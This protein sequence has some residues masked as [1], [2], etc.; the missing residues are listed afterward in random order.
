MISFN[1]TYSLILRRGKTYLSPEYANEQMMSITDTDGMP[2]CCEH[3]YYFFSQSI[4]FSA[5]K[6]FTR[7][8]VPIRINFFSPLDQKKN[9]F[10]SNQY[11]WAEFSLRIKIRTRQY[12]LPVENPIRC[13]DCI[14]IVDLSTHSAV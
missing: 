12:R 4:C 8:V 1:M 3:Y 2:S 7:P 10:S 14:D 6:T 13:I 5:W 11:T 9:H